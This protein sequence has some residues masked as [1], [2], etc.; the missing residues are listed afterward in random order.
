MKNDCLKKQSIAKPMEQPVVI[1]VWPIDKLVFYA[2]NPRK[3]DSAVDRMCGSI[4]EFGF[5]DSVFGAK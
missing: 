3:N 4:R 5:Q 1:Q 2:R